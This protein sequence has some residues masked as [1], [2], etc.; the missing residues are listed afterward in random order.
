MSKHSLI[1]NMCYGLTTL[2]HVSRN[3]FNRGLTHFIYHAFTFGIR[4]GRANP[5]S[6]VNCIYLI[7]GRRIKITLNYQNRPV[8]DT[9]TNSVQERKNALIMQFQAAIL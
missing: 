4:F 7:G 8:F 9:N 2:A 5:S 6:K 3:R 1:Q